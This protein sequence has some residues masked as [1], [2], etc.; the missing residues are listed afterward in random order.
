MILRYL[1]RRNG[2]NSPL[3]T[4]PVAMMLVTTGLMIL[5]IGVVWPRLSPAVAN[6]GTDWSDFFRGMAFGIAIA[7]EIAGVIL[8]VSAAAN[9]RNKL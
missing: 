7:L 5:S 6:I 8:A 2:Q 9:K 3:A 4:L 1:N